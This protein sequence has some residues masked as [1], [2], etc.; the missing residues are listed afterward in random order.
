MAH[1]PK[2]KQKQKQKSQRNTDKKQSE[3][4]IEAA[5]NLNAD[6]TEHFE[7]VFEKIVPAKKR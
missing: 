5:R 6:N 2:A 1:R 4:F 7:R 3:R